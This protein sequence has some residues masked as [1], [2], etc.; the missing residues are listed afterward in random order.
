MSLNAGNR[1]VDSTSDMMT[2]KIE[3]QLSAFLDGELDGRELEMLL[4]QLD[5]SPEHRAT[6]ARYSLAGDSL[7]HDELIPGALGLGERVREAIRTEPGHS[8]RTPLLRGWSTAKQGLFGT[9]IAATVAVIA[10]LGL[11]ELN[12]S[13]L[14]NDRA[15]VADIGGGVISRQNDISY[16]VPA[17]T[18]ITTTTNRTV[19][20]PA[21][22]TGY[23]VSHGEYSSLLSR[24]S[25]DSHIVSQLIDQSARS[26]PEED[27][28]EDT[29]P[30]SV[31]GPSSGPPAAGGA[32]PLR[33][34]L[35]D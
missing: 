33:D 1:P 6:M 35:N 34:N 32:A 25:M 12:Q 16:I 15:A 31:S 7:R 21:R 20:A 10:L 18:T 9:G 24:Q 26:L 23:L 27:D 19:L 28:E 30:F 29:E 14:V 8:G 4:H 13:P 22:L 5:K 2:G 17:T 11:G 3:E